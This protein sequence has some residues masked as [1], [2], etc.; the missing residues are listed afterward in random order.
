[1][2]TIHENFD[3]FWDEEAMSLPPECDRPQVHEVA[4]AS[5]DYQQAK[6][7]ELKAQIEKIYDQV[8]NTLD[9]LD[10]EFWKK[11]EK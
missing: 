9:A 6:I 11:E 4:K 3:E 10:G 5:W 7:D 8:G 2:K 1:M